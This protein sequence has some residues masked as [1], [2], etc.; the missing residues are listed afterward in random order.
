MMHIVDYHV[1]YVCL[2]LYCT[3]AQQRFLKPTYLIINRLYLTEAYVGDSPVEKPLLSDL[4]EALVG[5]DEYAKVPTN[6]ARKEQQKAKYDT[7]K[8]PTEEETE[9]KI[10]LYGSRYDAHER[11]KHAQYQA[12]AHNNRVLAEYEQHLLVV[13]LVFEILNFLFSFYSFFSHNR[14]C[15]ALP[16]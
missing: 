2:H 14:Y 4:Y 3:K 15:T 6:P 5:Y 8:Q 1:P 10:R 13:E 9:T 16:M 12:F 11:P 7:D